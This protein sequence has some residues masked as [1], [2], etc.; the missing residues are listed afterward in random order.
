MK[1]KKEHITGI[2]AML[3]VV[4]GVLCPLCF[5]APLLFAAGFGS[6]LITVITWLKPLL[7]VVILTALVGFSLSFKIHKNFLPI[8][9]TLI[10]G[11]SMY[12]GNYISY[13]PN[14]TY[15]GGFLLISALSLDWWFRKK[16]HIDCLECKVNLQ[17]HDKGT[18]YG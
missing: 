14:L 7:I 1:T 5:I 15:F 3:A 2:P 9:L 16:A 18:E 12:Y 17:H 11:G 4:L 6:I 8:V 10:A 13:N